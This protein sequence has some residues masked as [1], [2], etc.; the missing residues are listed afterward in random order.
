MQYQ[1]TLLTTFVFCCDDAVEP[2]G[3]TEV[4]LVRGGGGGDAQEPGRP[5]PRGRRP[6]G[7]GTDAGVGSQDGVST[8]FYDDH[9]FSR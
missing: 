1:T 5:D 3:R 6:G 8:G 9:L 2:R 4:L 7:E